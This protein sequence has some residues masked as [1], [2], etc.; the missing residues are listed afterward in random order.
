LKGTKVN[1]D[2]LLRGIDQADRKAVAER[3]TRLTAQGD[4]SEATRSALDK[5][6][7]TDPPVASA[8]PTASV[9]VGYDPKANTQAGPPVTYVSELITLLVGSPEFQKR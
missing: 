4:I 9:P 8:G 2:A 6:Q 5:V 3:I 1:V 7:Q